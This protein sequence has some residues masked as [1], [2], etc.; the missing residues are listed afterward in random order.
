MKRSTF[1]RLAG[2]SAFAQSS[3]VQATGKVERWGRYELALPGPQTGNPFVDVE[4]G[5]TFRHA[6]GII[7]ADGFYDG[8]GIYRVRCMPD[9][10]G[11]WT[12]QTRSNSKELDGKTGRFICL[13]PSPENHGPVSVRRV[14]HF[15]YADGAPYI[16]TGTT[17]YAW[18]HQGDELE[19][20]TLSTLR[21][22]PFNKMRMCVFPKHYAHNENEPPFYPFERNSSGQNDYARF[23]AAFFRHLEQRVSDLQQLGIEADLILLHPYDRWGFAEM[24]SEADDRYLRYIVA[25]LSAYRNVWWSVANEFNFMKKKTMADWDRFCRLI[26]AKDPYGHLLSIHNGGSEAD[27]LYDHS[28]SWITHVSVQSRH[29]RQGAE[30]RRRYAKPV[31]FDECYY[32]GNIARRWGNITAEEMVQRFWLGTVMGCYVGHGET[33]MH[34]QEILW[35]SK[36]GVL[37]GTSPER[38]RFLRHVLEDGPREGLDSFDSYYPSAGIAGDYYLYYFDLHRPAEYV[39][40]LPAERDFRVEILD[41]WN[42]KV[43]PIPGVHRGKARV[44]LPGRPY[45]A[46][47]IRS[48]G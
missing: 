27:V 46:A 33:Y 31:I 38:I 2:A 6:S 25:R 11:A 10:T 42:M 45:M 15:A 39:F 12:W 28:K 17:C 7:E 37:H 18:K 29:L 20:Q 36:G 44:T 21:K 19:E 26:R 16:P 41:P 13:A 23:N 3:G 48:A 43:E 5:A 22:A 40:E 47:R 8:E 1:L 30:F 24:S 4:F 35:W 32:E 9:S 34:P 14:H